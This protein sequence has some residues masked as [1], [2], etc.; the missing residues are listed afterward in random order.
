MKRTGPTNFQLQQLLLE[1][2][3]RA[4]GNRFW[5]RVLFDLKKSSRQRRTVNVYKIDR[6]ARDG[7]TV[8]VPGKVLSVGEINK[9][10]AV[11]AVNFSAEAKRKIIEAKGK[12]LSI[13]ELLQSN[14]DG[15]KVRILG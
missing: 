11:A 2:E 15:K 7:E 13:K 4:L 10:V 6:Y 1:L 3:N 8:L 12:A 5:K 9:P 14:P